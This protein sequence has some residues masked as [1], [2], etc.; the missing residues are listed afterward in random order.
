MNRRKLDLTAKCRSV[1][2]PE[3]TLFNKSVHK[4]FPSGMK[5]TK[6]GLYSQKSDFEICRYIEQNAAAY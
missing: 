5:R 4:D 3:G 1:F 2:H 6:G